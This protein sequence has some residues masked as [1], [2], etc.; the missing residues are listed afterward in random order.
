MA[1]RRLGKI[2]LKNTALFLCDMQEKFRPTI[3]FY[4]QVISV[5]NRLLKSAE[6]LNMP[7]VVTEQYPKDL[8][9]IVLTGIETH[10]CIQNTVLDLL[11]NNFDVHVIADACSSRS[12]T[13]RMFAFQRMKEAGAFITTSECILLGLCNDASHPKFKD[14][15]KIIW[16]SAPDTGL[17]SNKIQGETP[18]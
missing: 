1:A 10:V 15:Q 13:D 16:D 7:I 9:S 12:M 17:L 14:I 5:A 18:V 3:K 2:N 4:P 11:E 8:K 6:I